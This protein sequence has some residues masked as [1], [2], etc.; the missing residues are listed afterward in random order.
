MSTTIKLRRSSTP[1][2]VPSLAQ[3]AEGEV[4]LN[5]VDG[6]LY[7]RDSSTIVEVGLN[8]SGDVTV[9]GVISGNGSGLTNVDAITLNGID[10]NA[11][12]TTNANAI[13]VNAGDIATNTSNIATNT[14]QILI[15]SFDILTNTGNINQINA[16]LP[17]G[18][19]D[20]D[21]LVWN[22]SFNVY[23]DSTATIQEDGTSFFTMLKV[24]A[25]DFTANT[26]VHV[27]KSGAN[28]ALRLETDAGNN[29]QIQLTLTDSPTDGQNI[30]RINFQTDNNAGGFASG[31][32]IVAK[33]DG[34]HVAGSDYSSKIE[35]KTHNG[36]TLQDS[37]SVDSAQIVRGLWSN[38]SVANSS[39]QI[40][41]LTQAQYDAL[42]PDTNTLY[43]I[44]G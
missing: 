22:S 19:V 5:A 43:F 11:N 7:V 23:A 9:G 21:L 33:A 35:F 27:M 1:G 18:T 40:V 25:A 3:L 26:D 8:P 29:A 10:T 15:N 4:A 20:G 32:Q 41:V 14:G 36:S 6:R 30:G 16:R 37:L 24:G 2:S 42:T 38:N 39:S 44:S 31:A 13:S 34:N 28:A 12:V 17:N